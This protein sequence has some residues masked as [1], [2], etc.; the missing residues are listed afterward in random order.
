MGQAESLLKR[1]DSKEGSC[2]KLVD[3][4]F[5]KLDT[6]GNGVLEG[7]EYDIL[8]KSTTEYIVK[9]YHDNGAAFDQSELRRWVE[10][11]LDPNQDKKVTKVELKGNLKRLLAAE[12]MIA[13]S[14]GR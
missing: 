5:N 13:R 4:M 10:Q 7:K 11:T 2:D 14:H 8:M 6:D 1:I 12:K 3:K 9:N